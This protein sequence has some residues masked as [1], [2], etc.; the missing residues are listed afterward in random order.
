MLEEQ[1]KLLGFAQASSFEALRYRAYTL[2]KAWTLVSDAH[3][4]LVD[5]QLYV[6]V[7]GRESEA[8]FVQMVESLVRAGVDILQLRDKSLDDQT[9]LSR[10]RHLRRLAPRGGP[11]LVIVND[12]PDLALLAQADGVHVGQKELTVR[13]V[14]TVVGPE[15]LVGV[16]THDID[17]AR[18]A[19]VEGASYIG[20]GPTF[21]STTKHFEQFAGL[22]FLEQ[23]AGEIGLP[24][25]AIGGITQSNLS[26]VLAVGFTRVAVSGSITGA[27]D[28]EEE[29]RLMLQMLRT[30]RE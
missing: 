22:G 20:C 28:A 26:E 21:P 16:S 27:M 9:L 7:D 1:A 14:R 12:R 2:A 5:A 25:F 15:M 13:E 24:A 30:S 18:T 10:A 11:T 17:Q 8:A 6:L 3:Q 4:R 29:A 19:V 23:V